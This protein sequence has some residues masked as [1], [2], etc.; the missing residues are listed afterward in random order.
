MMKLSRKETTQKLAKAAMHYFVHKNYSCHYEFGV[1][2]WGKRRLDLLCLNLKGNLVGIEV[3]S[4]NADYRADSKWKEYLPFCNKLYLL[5]PPKM[6]KSKFYPQIL[7]DLK[8]WGVGVMTLG[9]NGYIQVVK[10]AKSRDVDTDVSRNILMKMAWRSGTSK[11]E[12]K[13]RQRTVLE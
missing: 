8:P 2:K 12:V 10:S 11:R 1:G 3:K 6:L 7:S 4:C 9:E 5:I 13:R